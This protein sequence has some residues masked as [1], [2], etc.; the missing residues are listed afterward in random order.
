MN[1]HQNDIESQQRP[2][3]EGIR[4]HYNRRPGGF[5][6]A[7]LLAIKIGQASIP[8]AMLQDNLKKK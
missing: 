7:A 4:R 2:L 6:Q 5:S 1:Q 3:R 8:A